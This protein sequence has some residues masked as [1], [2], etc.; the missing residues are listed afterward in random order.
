[1]PKWVHYHRT[2]DTASYQSGG[3]SAISHRETRWQP[4]RLA[5]AEVTK[6]HRLNDLNL[7]NFFSHSSGDWKSKIK[8]PAGSV[9]GKDVLLGLQ[10]AAASLLCAHTV[11]RGES[12]RSAA[13]SYKDT[14]P[15]G[16]MLSSNTVSWEVST[17]T[18]KFGVRVGG[19]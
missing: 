13:S 12:T 4:S 19:G 6:D 9:S 1:M 18:Y 15:I 7:R 8:V 14:N 11:E 17:S 2:S 3:Q 16:V 5:W 10:M